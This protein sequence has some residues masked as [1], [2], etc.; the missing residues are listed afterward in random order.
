MNMEKIIMI[1][2]SWDHQPLEGYASFDQR[3]C[4]FTR[5]FSSV[6]DEWSDEYK[7]TFVSEEIIQYA[8]QA[9]AL[10]RYWKFDKYQTIDML[11]CYNYRK[12][13]ESSTFEEI[14]AQNQTCTYEELKAMEDNYHNETLIE[15]YLKDALSINALAT[16]KGEYSHD[17]L[18]P[19]YFVEWRRL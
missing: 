2:D 15:E 12:A 3:L 4:H 10:F 6:T 13:R 1:T 19:D 11:H 14:L 5:L 8:I 18:Y 16:F 17:D 7:I 9:F